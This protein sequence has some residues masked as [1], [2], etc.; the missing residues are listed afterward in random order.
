VARVQGAGYRS[1]S[2]GRAYGHGSYSV[3][4]TRDV[5]TDEHYQR[6]TELEQVNGVAMVNRL[7]LPEK[8]QDD[9]ELRQAAAKLHADILLIYTLDTVFSVDNDLAPLSVITLGLSPN[10]KA[11]VRS[12]ASAVLMDTR[13]GYIYGVMESSAHGDQLANSWTSEAAVDQVRRRV[14]TE[15]FDDLVGELERLWPQI[16][17]QYAAGST[18]LKTR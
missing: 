10:E 18:A 7:L 4:T 15:A 14:E 11:R 13:N 6:I 9:Y 12:T 5:E 2:Y 8:L 3:V 17:Q 16:V 1:Y